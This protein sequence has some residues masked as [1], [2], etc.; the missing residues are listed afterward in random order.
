MVES[1]DTK[2]EIISLTS[3]IIAGK[4]SSSSYDTAWIAQLGD[5]DRE[6][7][8][9][10]LAWLVESQL[11]DGSWGAENPYY[12]HDRVV[13]TLAAMLA[14]TR[15]GRRAQ[16]KKV[17]DKGLLA[18]DHI[19]SIATGGLKADHNGATVG[20][21]VIVPTLVKEAEQLGIIKQQKNRILGRLGQS[22]IKKIELLKGNRISR[23]LSYAFSSEMAGLDGQGIL[24]VDNLQEANGAVGNSPSATAYFALN[25]RPADKRA[26]DYLR[27]TIEFDRG[28]PFAAPFD[29]FERA[30]VLWNLSL[31]KPF[32]LDNEILALCAPHLDFLESS[33]VPNHGVGFAASYTPCDGDDTGVTFDT[34]LQFG[35]QVDIETLL[36]FEERNYFRCYPLEANPSISTNIHI[37]GALKQAGFEKSH[38]I[39]KKVL[40]FLRI[41]RLSGKYWFDKWHISPY[42]PTA[43][44]IIACQGLDDEICSDAITW[45]LETQRE[46][47]SWGFNNTP[48][49]EET[50]Y[51]IQA[52]VF[53][54]NNYGHISQA[55]IKHG[56]KWLDEHSIEPFPP[57]GMGKGLYCPQNIVHS[58]ILSARGMA[59]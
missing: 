18:L 44:A 20:F 10:A 28:V 48:T 45:I 40:E 50:A 43:H 36:S 25:L 12:Y 16:D 3:T 52:L 29:I 9:H 8:N 57:L 53:W 5:M 24:D 41:N 15:N 47:G 51:C 35:R 6:L 14:L 1:M 27:K 42:Y 49:A 37:L 30:W 46:D 4:M 11:P 32:C 26:L 7:S 39:I 21:E 34:L 56:I 38:P 31:L 23:Q 55:P 17:I 2:A 33:W 13:N 59:S 22:R 58:A 19:T 54:Q